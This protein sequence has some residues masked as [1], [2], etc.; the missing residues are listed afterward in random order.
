MRQV[1]AVVLAGTMLVACSLYFVDD[2]PR[3]EID[4]GP[5]DSHHGRRDAGTVDAGPCCGP[6]ASPDPCDAGAP[7]DGP[8]D[9]SLVDA[10]PFD[11]P[12]PGD[13]RVPYDDAAPDGPLPGDARLPY[14]DAAPD[15]PLSSDGGFPVDAPPPGDASVPDDGAPF[16]GALPSDG[17]LPF[18]GPPYIEGIAS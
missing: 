12:L 18:D 15:G 8:P 4:A 5:G 6:D 13:A 11:A 9:G 10:L 2:S 1:F 7:F 17:G 3:F 14:D 16:D